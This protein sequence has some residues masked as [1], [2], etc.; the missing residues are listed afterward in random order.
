MELI[1]SVDRLLAANHT[2]QAAAGEKFGSASA[3]LFDLAQVANLIGVFSHDVEVLDERITGDSAVV[4]IQVAKRV[5][6]QQV[7]LVRRD[8]RWLIQTDPPIEGVAAE[9]RN[10]ADVLVDAVDILAEKSLTLEELRGEVESRQKAVGRRLALLAE[11]PAP[12]ADR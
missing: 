7:R 11:R 12:L 5:P 2:L 8:G 6:L 9:V 4:T 1:Q 10:L 3:A